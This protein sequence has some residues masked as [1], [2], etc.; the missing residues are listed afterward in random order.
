MK[1][2]LG[3]AI[4][5]VM[6]LSLTACGSK[7]ENKA[8]GGNGQPSTTQ[9]TKFEQFEAGLNDAGITYEKVTMAAE[10]VGTSTGVKYEIGDGAIELYEF[11]P[12]SDACKTMQEKKALTMEGFGDFPV[13]VNGSLAMLLSELD[14]GTQSKA[15]ELFGALS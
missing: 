6:L 7:G 15:L 11:D 1:R 8:S 13:E 12:S 3:I 10:I 4:S 9:Q 2:V 5:I 14:D